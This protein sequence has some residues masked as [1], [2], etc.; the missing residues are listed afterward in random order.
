MIKS[1]G[2]D[3]L[4]LFEPRVFED[5]RGYFF[6]SWNRKVWEEA[7]IHHDWVQ[8]NESFSNY[9]VLRGLHYQVAPY[10][11]AKLVRV[12]SGVVLD[13]AVDIRPNSPS[14]GQYFSEVLS[15]ENKRQMLIPRG[16]AHGFVVLSPQARFNYKCDGYYDK[17]SEGSIHPLDPSLNIDWIL[18]R[19][20]LM[21]SAKDQEAPNFENHRKLRR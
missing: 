19:S 5:D 6:E 12:T 20:D 11:Q 14:F 9:G 15:A 8:D 17:E 1:T 10:E 2:I 13:V 21:L 18:K 16:C 4:Y 7:G 3:G